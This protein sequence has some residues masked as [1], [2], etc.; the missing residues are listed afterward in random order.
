MAEDEEVE[1]P[2][3]GVC[4]FS[5]TADDAFLKPAKTLPAVDSGEPG[6]VNEGDGGLNIL[7]ARG[8][9]IPDALLGPAGVEVAVEGIADGGGDRGG[10]AGEPYPYPLIAI[11]GV[12]EDLFFPEVA[13]GA[14]VAVLKEDLVGEGV[15]KVNWGDVG[16]G[17]GECCDGR[18]RG[19]NDDDCRVRGRREPLG[20]VGNVGVVGDAEEGASE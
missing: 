9:P 18:G 19:K 14:V 12:V 5:S 4:V 17:D 16:E 2:G 7:V 11:A 1:G 8:R 6:D 3:V 20:N 15:P 13:L 10:D